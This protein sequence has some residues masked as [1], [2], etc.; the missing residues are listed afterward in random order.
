MQQQNTN[1]RYQH[2]NRNQQQQQQHSGVYNASQ[3]TR[4]SS[5]EQRREFLWR[6]RVKLEMQVQALLASINGL[7][8]ERQ[9]LQK[10]KDELAKKGPQLAVQIL[11]LGMTRMQT[12]LPAE[13]LYHY[14]RER[15]EQEEYRLQQAHID[16]ANQAIALQGQINVLDVELSLL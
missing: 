10:K 4:H 2:H 13:R 14:H 9:L 3:Q 7:V 5:V 1:S 16:Y 11:M 15:I 8:R 6:E 12:T